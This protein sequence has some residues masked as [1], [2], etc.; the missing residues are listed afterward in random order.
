MQIEAKGSSSLYSLERQVQRTSSASFAAIDEMKV[1]CTYQKK[2]CWAKG[3]T[4]IYSFW[5]NCYNCWYAKII[6]AKRRRI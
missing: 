2:N 1:R 6:R 4:H 3:R 5:Q